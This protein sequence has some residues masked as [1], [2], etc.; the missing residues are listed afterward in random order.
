MAQQTDQSWICEACGW[1]YDPLEGDPDSGI[2]P[3]THFEQI[4]E[5]WCCPVC[6]AKKS[7]FVLF[8]R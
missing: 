5:N 7:D 1:I 6:G 8:S 2:Q 4:P 3:G